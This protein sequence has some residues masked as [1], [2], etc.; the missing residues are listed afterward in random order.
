MDKKKE[1]RKN[2]DGEKKYKKHRNLSQNNVYGY[3]QDERKAE[4]GIISF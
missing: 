1:M 4:E 3:Q 2:K